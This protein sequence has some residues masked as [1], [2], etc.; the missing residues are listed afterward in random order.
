M[1]YSKHTDNNSKGTCNCCGKP[2][3]DPVSVDLGI[4]PVCRVQNKMKEAGERTINMFANRSSYDWGISSDGKVLY[5]TDQG[6]Y[7]SVTNDMENVLQDISN[8]LSVQDLRGMKIMYRD[9]MGIWDEVRLSLSD[10]L[11]IKGVS[12]SPLT[13][14]DFNKAFEKIVKQN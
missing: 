7:K 6:G 10:D 11:I 3:S 14:R 8:E 1:N 13:E 12:F 9:S 4:G 2:L 5:I